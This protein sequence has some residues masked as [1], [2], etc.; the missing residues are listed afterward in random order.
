MA[1]GQ[2][3][4]CATSSGGA[5]RGGRR[6]CVFAGAG[7][8]LLPEGVLGSAE[9]CGRVVHA[10][11]H[12][13]AGVSYPSPQL[14]RAGRRASSKPVT[15]AQRATAMKAKVPVEDGGPTALADASRRQSVRAARTQGLR[16]SATAY[17]E[18]DASLAA[19]F[20]AKDLRRDS[21]DLAR[22][23]RA[24]PEEQA[25]WR[26]A[27][28]SPSGLR[29]ATSPGADEPTLVP[30]RETSGASPTGA[31]WASATQ[32]SEARVKNPVVGTDGSR[33]PQATEHRPDPSEL[34][35][36]REAAEPVEGTGI[37][38]G[39]AVRVGAPEGGSSPPTGGTGAPA[40]SPSWDSLRA[41]LLAKASAKS[42]IAS[43]PASGPGPVG[44][45]KA[46]FEDFAVGKKGKGGGGG[47][48]GPAKGPKASPGAGSSAGPT[49]TPK[50][51]GP[52]PAPEAPAGSPPGGGANPPKDKNGGKPGDG[53]GGA[54]QEKAKPCDCTCACATPP[55]TPTEPDT[56][57][58]H[59][60]TYTVMYQA[61]PEGAGTNG[62]PAASP[63]GSPNPKSE[64]GTSS[65][66]TGTKPGDKDKG[67]QPPGGDVS[68]GGGGKAEKTTGPLDVVRPPVSVELPAPRNVQPPPKSPPLHP[69]TTLDPSA[70]KGF[71]STPG[72]L[73]QVA[74]FEPGW[75]APTV[76]QV[77]PTVG[78]SPRAPGPFGSIRQVDR[79]DSPLVPAEGFHP[80]SARA[81]DSQARAPITAPSAS[82]ASPVAFDKMAAFGDLG[83]SPSQS[84]LA[85]EDLFG[86]GAEGNLG[87]ADLGAASKASA[88]LRGGR[89][90]LPPPPTIEQL[91]VPT[92]RTV[93]SPVAQSVGGGVPGGGAPGHPAS[94]G[95]AAG[96]RTP[97]LRVEALPVAPPGTGG[98]PR[99]Q[100]P[101]SSR[102][103][104][105]GM[106]PAGTFPSSRSPR[107]DSL[108]ARMPGGGTV[109]PSNAPAHEYQ[110]GMVSGFGGESSAS[111]PKR[112]KGPGAVEQYVSNR[113]ELA[114]LTAQGVRLY[115]E[116]EDA[117]SRAEEAAANA[118]RIAQGM[119]RSS[120]S[121]SSTSSACRS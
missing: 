70:V 99:Q 77:G 45:P 105:Q 72:A 111:A 27:G 108:D 34:L 13:E 33:P 93:P 20:G 120:P 110:A 80:S 107:W 63:E 32:G 71:A 68:S 66:G 64:D 10:P 8:L 75:T 51:Q 37:R 114:R 29:L 102:P 18:K 12:E 39:E 89:S 19:A 14:P 24:E 59:S 49:P 28:R 83:T 53:K 60:G 101:P 82:Y 81:R 112:G 117:R 11:L 44:A 1:C 21:A 15:R 116:R 78:P 118:D 3:C 31:K 17:Q 96:A 42:P 16:R 97:A 87:Q 47:G 88:V 61:P 92:R 103:S 69:G 22:R 74:E 73:P 121:R 41:G 26:G 67:G 38:T 48:G 90:E 43:A 56:P 91:A 65:G 25:K 100:V 23:R 7:R 50:P 98:N 46:P 2:S 86:W 113:K 30:R 58:P 9:D 85:A 5:K 115:D 55:I 4:G 104:P 119:T 84:N 54:P 40:P 109:G 36:T 76:W 52:K 57:A 94:T 95:P 62:G 6:P 35:S 79:T 106:A